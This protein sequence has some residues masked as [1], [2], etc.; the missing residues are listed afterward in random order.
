M[1]RE[2]GDGVLEE[3]TGEEEGVKDGKAV[4]QVRKAPFQ[5]NILLVKCP[6]TQ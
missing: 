1:L 5:L 3:E 4:Q 2:G 6:H